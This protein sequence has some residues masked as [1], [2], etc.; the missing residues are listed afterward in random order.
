MENEHIQEKNNK[1]QKY[2]KKKPQYLKYTGLGFQML[3]SIL[4]G[5]WLGA[6]L[7]TLMK[8]ELPIFTIVFIF[9]FFIGSM[10]VL[11]KNLPK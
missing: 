2:T 6:K 4:V 9:I 10:I 7:D 8:M 5:A 11:V 3:A 1:G